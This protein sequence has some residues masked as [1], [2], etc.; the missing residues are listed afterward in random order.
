MLAIWFSK[1]SSRLQWNVVLFAVCFPQCQVW[2]CAA[3]QWNVDLV[4]WFPKYE[5]WSCA[6]GRGRVSVFAV[7]VVEI[8]DVLRCLRCPT[9]SR[10]SSCRHCERRR[11]PYYSLAADAAAADAADT[12]AA[13]AAAG[14]SAESVTLT[15]L[16]QLDAET[17]DDLVTLNCLHHD[18]HPAQ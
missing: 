10:W 18:V 3:G 5:V 7:A 13:A 17:S 16:H 14:G 1:V 4:A 8:A 12:A 2:S 15:F 6:A 11:Q 9:R